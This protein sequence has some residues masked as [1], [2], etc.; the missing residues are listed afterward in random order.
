MRKFDGEGGQTLIMVAGSMVVLIGM[1]G[2][3]VDMGV[4]LHQRREVQTAADAAAIGA[5]TEALIE[6]TSSVSSGVYAAG[7]SDAAEDGYTASTTNGSLNSTTGMTLT[8][9]AGTNIAI[10]P[11]NKSGNFQAI[12]T[13]AQPTYFMQFLMNSLGGSFSSVNV[14]ATAIASDQISSNGCF[15]VDNPTDYQ[16]NA[17]DLSGNSLASAQHCGITVNGNLDLSSGSAEVDAGYLAVSGTIANK[18]T[19][20]G[21]S[22]EN[23][24]PQS[25]PADLLGLENTSE[26]PSSSGTPGHCTPPAGSGYTVANCYINA[27]LSGSL[28]GLYEYTQAPVFG[29]ATTAAGGATTIFL[30][31]AFPFAAE[32]NTLN[33]TGPASGTLKGIVIDAPGSLYQAS[34][35]SCQHGNKNDSVN[36]TIETNFGSSGTT[37]N[38]IVYAPDAHLYAQDQGAGK[39]TVNTDFV[40][41]T[42]CQQSANLVLA[43]S[44]ANNPI[45]R[46]G[47]VY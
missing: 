40:I 6:G 5:A 1:L 39:T 23:A 29:N 8:I 20:T 2:F 4:I 22:A 43:G 35:N 46:V 12:I 32:N 34:D 14:G 41:G 11:F 17:F 31:G 28:N 36:G 24:P 25:P 9:T 13:Y 26:Q 38:G 19:I 42:V 37:L 30:D 21:P 15:W 47:L 44:A 7:Y 45:T 33:I 3:A 18:G 10:S 27:P 16:P